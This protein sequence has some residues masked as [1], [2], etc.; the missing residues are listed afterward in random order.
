[1]HNIIVCYLSSG[2]SEQSEKSRLKSVFTFFRDA[3]YSGKILNTWRFDCYFWTI[4]FRNQIKTVWFQSHTFIL[5]DRNIIISSIFQTAIGR[6]YYV[7]LFMKH[8]YSGACVPKDVAERICVFVS[9]KSK[10]FH[11]SLLNCQIWLLS[12][13]TCKGNNIGFLC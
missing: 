12:P 8:A 4:Y 7:M 2:G 13:S 10:V 5:R 11:Y 6:R 3:M 9:Q 1:M